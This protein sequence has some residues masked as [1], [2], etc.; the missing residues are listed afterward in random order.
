MERSLQRMNHLS[1]QRMHGR[2]TAAACSARQG[3]LCYDKLSFG[4][5]RPLVH[6]PQKQN[7]AGSDGSPSSTSPVLLLTHGAIKQSFQIA[8]TTNDPTIWIR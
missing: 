7:M 5:S 8:P 1:A 3:G 2:T 4:P 6:P